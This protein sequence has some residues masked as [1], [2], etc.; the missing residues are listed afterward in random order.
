MAS[1]KFVFITGLALS[2]AAQLKAQTTNPITKETVAEALK[3]IGLH[4]S[5]QKLEMLPSGL[6]SR[7]PDYEAIR[8][9]E[10]PYDVF[11]AV[12]FN[13]IPVGFRMPT[14]RKTPVF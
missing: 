8:K 14:E 12:L 1:A 7:L 9:V 4:F 5:E 13:P 6:S 3:I 11:P 2:L 10:I